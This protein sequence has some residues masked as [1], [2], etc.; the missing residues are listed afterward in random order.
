M[1]RSTAH[2]FD[3]VAK[4][5]NTFIFQVYY[6]FVHRDCIN[7]LKGC[8][9]DNYKILD[10]ACGTGNFLKKIDK[11]NKRLK[12]F[13]IDN[14]TGM[15][16]VANQHPGA[17]NFKVASAEKIPFEDNSFDLVTV[18]DAF[19]YFQDNGAALKE[20][21]RVLKPNQYLFIFYPAIDIFPKFF[22][23]II[24]IVS[25]SLLFNLE[26]YS[27]FPNMDELEK[28]AS[29]ANLKPTVKKNKL[30]HR[31]ILLRKV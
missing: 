14:S 3:K 18:I 1:E 2:K 24:Q 19:Y 17:I 7:F 12:L 27:E 31:F 11:K 26:E 6:F 28:M 25:R 4:I 22:L 15:I 8:I 13:G 16:S 10:V 29:S 20:C 9:E 21:S 30:M 23:K 5:Y